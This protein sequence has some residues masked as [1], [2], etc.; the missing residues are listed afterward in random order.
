MYT[1]LTEVR[2]K[3]GE[4]MEVGSVLAPDEEF[5]DRVKPF[6]AHKGGIWNWH[7]ERSLGEQ[8]DE[9]ETQYYIGLL[10]DNIISNIMIV[11]HRQLYLSLFQYIVINMILNTIKGGRS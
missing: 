5:A 2:L 9:L 3:T 6:L 4:I 8:L 10:G 1:K 11:E 7:I